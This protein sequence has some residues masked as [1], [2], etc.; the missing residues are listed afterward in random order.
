MPKAGSNNNHNNKIS[1]TNHHSNHCL[2]RF[3]FLVLLLVGLPSTASSLSDIPSHS[4]SSNANARA[5]ARVVVHNPEEEDSVAEE[6]DFK[7]TNHKPA[8]AYSPPHSPAGIA[9]SQ[10]EQGYVSLI[11]IM[12][13]CQHKKKENVALRRHSI[14]CMR[15]ER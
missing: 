2:V 11:Y 9:A 7:I 15:I 12:H 13:R 8:S 6:E 5:A 3:L 4:S 14:Y 1:Y 10:Q